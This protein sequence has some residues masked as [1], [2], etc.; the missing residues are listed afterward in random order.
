MPLKDFGLSVHNDAATCRCKFSFFIFVKLFSFLLIRTRISR[1][2]TNVYSI[3]FRRARMLW[4]FLGLDFAAG[5][6]V[7]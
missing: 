7:V 5:R 4:V 2:G 3:V 1:M 6:A